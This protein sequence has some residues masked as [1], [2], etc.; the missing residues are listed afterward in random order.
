M[1]HIKTV[2]NKIII[3]ILSN[4]KIVNDIKQEINSQSKLVGYLKLNSIF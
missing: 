4:I 2:D 1:V 3:E